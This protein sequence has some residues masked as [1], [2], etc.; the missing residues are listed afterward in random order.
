MNFAPESE[1]EGF[2]STH[3]F[4]HLLDAI[5]MPG[6]A[7][8]RYFFEKEDHTQ[9]VFTIAKYLTCLRVRTH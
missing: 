1:R 2:L 8:L 6:S 9:S 3:G 4:G 7:T 5:Q